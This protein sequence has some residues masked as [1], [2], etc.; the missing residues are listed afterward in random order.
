VRLVKIMILNKIFEILKYLTRF[1][2][3]PVFEFE[4]EFFSVHLKLK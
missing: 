1:F 2:Q 4:E 3:K